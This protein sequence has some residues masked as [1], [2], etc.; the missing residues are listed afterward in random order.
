MIRTILKTLFLGWL[1]KR[2]ARGSQ[3]PAVPRRA[4]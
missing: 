3:R 2:A 4:D 1:A